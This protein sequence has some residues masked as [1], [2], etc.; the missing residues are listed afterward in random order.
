MEKT[1]NTEKTETSIKKSI[2]LHFH[3]Y[4]FEKK[5]HT[6]EKSIDGQKH[7]YLYGIATGL[8]KDGD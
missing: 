5:S 1:E 4:E 8:A 2:S 3:P 6:V 7:R